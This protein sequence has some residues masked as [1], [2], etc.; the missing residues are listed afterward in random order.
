MYG[1]TLTAELSVNTRCG[2][3]KQELASSG[4]PANLQ[5]I[6][7][8]HFQRLQHLRVKLATNSCSS[9]FFGFA[10]PML[11]QWNASACRVILR[12]ARNFAGIS[13]KREGMSYLD[14]RRDRRG[15]CVSGGHRKVGLQGG[16][17]GVVRC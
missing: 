10:R 13:W 9:F 5:N 17:V 1:C 3:F 2:N 7:T 4:F 15:R 6:I 11:A 12:I 8:F 14:T 16:T